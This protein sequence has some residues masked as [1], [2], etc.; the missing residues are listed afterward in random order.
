MLTLSVKGVTDVTLRDNL[1]MAT[2]RWRAESCRAIRMLRKTKGMMNLA[3]ENAFLK[4][5]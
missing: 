2:T 1:P 5:E 4:Y 3:A